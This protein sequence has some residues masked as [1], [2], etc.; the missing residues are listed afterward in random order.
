MSDTQLSA[1]NFLF[2]APPV[3]MTAV[4]LRLFKITSPAIDF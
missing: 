3:P 1:V 2:Q 4:K